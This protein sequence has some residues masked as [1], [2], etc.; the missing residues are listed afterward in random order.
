MTLFRSRLDHCPS[1]IGL[2]GRPWSNRWVV[3]IPRSACH[4]PHCRKFGTAA[5]ESLPVRN[6]LRLIIFA[7]S[8]ADPTIGKTRSR[9]LLPG[10]AVWGHRLSVN[11]VPR[12]KRFNQA[13]TDL[14]RFNRLRCH[15][16]S[17]HIRARTRS[18]KLVAGSKLLIRILPKFTW[19]QYSI[20]SSRINESQLYVLVP[21]FH[22]GVR[23]VIWTRGLRQIT[24][25]R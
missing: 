7:A 22:K 19:A 3:L 4:G 8:S 20:F 16:V 21:L 14:Y 17:I 13:W 24:S 12:W 6:G 25:H 18:E 10:V 2:S 11:N 9:G 5:P 15:D 23:L 1:T